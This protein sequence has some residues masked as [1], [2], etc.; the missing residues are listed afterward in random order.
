MNES[1]LLVA[2]AIDG[3]VKSVTDKHGALRAAL[4]TGKNIEKAVAA[5]EEEIKKNEDKLREF[6]GL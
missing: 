2:F 5:L 1:G 3:G 4:K 6:A